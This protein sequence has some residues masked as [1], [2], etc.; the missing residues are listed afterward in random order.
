[1]TNEDRFRQRG[2]KFE[3][4]NRAMIAMI[5]RAAPNISVYDLVGVQP[6]TG[7]T[8]QIFYMTPPNTIDK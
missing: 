3:G 2:P 1:M 5:R 8:G 7:P 4:F 6:M